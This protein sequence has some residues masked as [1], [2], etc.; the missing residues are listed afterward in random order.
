MYLPSEVNKLRRAPMTITIYS[1]SICAACHTLTQWLDKIN[2]PYIK[3]IT[4][5]DP[6]VM[7]E[8]M[9]VNDGMIGVPFSVIKTDD[10]V[11]TKISG[12]DQSAFKKV[13][14]I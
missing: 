7:M 6:A 1:T 8:F 11:E 14:G 3:K 12:F 4:D 13:L 5:E 2:Q 10:G 9:Q